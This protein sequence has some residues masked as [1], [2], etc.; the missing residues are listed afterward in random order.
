[1][2]TKP[3]VSANQFTLGDEPV[4]ESVEPT[5]QA[6]AKKR[7]PKKKVAT[8]PTSFG[9]LDPER[10]AAEV[11]VA[12]AEGWDVAYDIGWIIPERRRCHP[13]A[14]FVRK[15]P[16]ATLEVPGQ[17]ADKLGVTKQAVWD[18]DAGLCGRPFVEDGIL[19]HHSDAYAAGVE[20]RKR[21]D[22]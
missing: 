9:A 1:V 11:K 6:A 10:I 8:A 15:A 17:L 2:T 12:V 13:L 18:F 7:A 14:T 4:I 21:L 20:V 5:K 16:A 3:K 19:V 22:E